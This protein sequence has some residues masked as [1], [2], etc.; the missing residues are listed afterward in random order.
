MLLTKSQKKLIAKIDSDVKNSLAQGVNTFTLFIQLQ[1]LM[2]LVKTI[3]YSAEKKELDLYL[4]S[5][6]GFY[7]YVNLIANHLLH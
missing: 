2:P 3:L 5:Y 7:R 1:E 4:Y 6:E